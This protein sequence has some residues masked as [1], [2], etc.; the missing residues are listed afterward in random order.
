MAN[1]AK[2]FDNF[3]K[4]MYKSMGF[5]NITASMLSFL[6]IEPGEVSLEKISERTGYSLASISNKVKILEQVGV[7]Y[8]IKKPKSKK[9][10]LFFEKDILLIQENKIL[11]ARKLML[12]PVKEKL[13]QIIEKYKG[14]NLNVKEKKQLANLNHLYKR[15]KQL[16]IIMNDLL[17]E[18]KKMRMKK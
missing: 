14:A 15:F 8:R 1:I 7:V 13:P 18:I 3:M 17:K 6:Y 11:M 2:D 9:V 4:K 5:D 10:Y 16:D 12:N